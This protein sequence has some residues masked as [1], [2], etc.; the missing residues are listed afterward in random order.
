[1]TPEVCK[2]LEMKTSDIEQEGIQSENSDYGYQNLNFLT[3]FLRVQGFHDSSN[4]SH[5]F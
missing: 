2:L 5:F 3:E 4:E 1:M